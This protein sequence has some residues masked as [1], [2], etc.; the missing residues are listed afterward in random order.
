MA[1]QNVVLPTPGITARFDPRA[2]GVPV[3]WRGAAVSLACVSALAGFAATGQAASAA[4]MHDAGPDLAMLLR[5]MAMVKAMFALGLVSLAAWRLGFPARPG[6]VAA[7]V[8]ACVLMPA[9]VGLIWHLA[10]VVAGAVLFHAG[11]LTMLA[12]GWADQ[13]DAGDLVLGALRRRV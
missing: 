2:L 9:G 10:H 7:Y 3:G 8:A 13:D 11:L 5:F 6:V 4:A 12:V 1:E